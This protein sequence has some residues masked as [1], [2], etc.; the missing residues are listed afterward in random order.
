MVDVL[1]KIAEIENDRIEA[2]QRP[3]GSSGFICLF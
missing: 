2:V 3:T 1:E